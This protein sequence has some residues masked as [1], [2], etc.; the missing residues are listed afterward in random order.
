MKNL[1]TSETKKKKSYGALEEGSLI[2]EALEFMK[3]QRQKRNHVQFGKYDNSIDTLLISMHLLEVPED[4]S[5]SESK[6]TIRMCSAPY[7]H[8]SNLC[9]LA[10]EILLECQKRIHYPWITGGQGIAFGIEVEKDENVAIPHLKAFCVYGAAVQDEWYAISLCYYLSNELF[11]R[12]QYKVAIEALDL[13]DGQILLI[14]SAFSLPRWVDQIGPR[15]IRNRVWIVQN[16]LHL[17]T[18]PL[19]GDRIDSKVCST[20]SDAFLSLQ[21]SIEILRKSTQPASNASTT[22]ASEAIQKALLPRT[23]TFRQMLQTICSRSNKMKCQNEVISHN[24]SMPLMKTTFQSNIHRAA[25]VLPL[26]LAILIKKRPDLT[27]SAVMC[28]CAQAPY[29]FNKIKSVQG[30]NSNLQTSMLENNLILAKHFP[31]QNLVIAI[32]HFTKVGY[33]SLMTGN[34]KI[35]LFNLPHEYR[36]IE[37]TRISRKC[38]IDTSAHFRNAV[39]TGVRLSCGFEWLY[40]Q[41]KNNERRKNHESRVKDPSSYM[42][43]IEK[44][45][46]LYWTRIDQECGGD[47]M[48]IRQCWANGPNGP[49]GAAV[50][51]IGGEKNNRNKTKSSIEHLV[52]CPVFNPEIKENRSLCPLSMI[53]TSI[54]E[55]ICMAIK[56]GKKDNTMKNISSYEMPRAQDVDSDNWMNLSSKELD[57]L[58]NETLSKSGHSNN[59]HDSC[60]S[61]KTESYQTKQTV[62]KAAT[63]SKEIRQPTDTEVLDSILSG[64]KSFV[65]TSSEID[66]VDLGSR[67]DIAFDVSSKKNSFTKRMGYD[68]KNEKEKVFDAYDDYFSDEE[69]YDDDTI[70]S[71]KESSEFLNSKHNYVINDHNGLK[72]R[73]FMVSA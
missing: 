12:Y 47:G 66:G 14:E 56:S 55:Q 31:F 73:D 13:E 62:S 18:P 20:E 51:Q 64:F 25:V 1:E 35:P 16:F 49:N 70:S 23:K 50:S 43:D 6:K 54:H 72:M 33:S 28:F 42:G 68:S 46:L 65:K 44:R 9:V 57:N 45:I 30:S 58:M 36:S 15:G 27:S 11:T 10:N 4:S 2:A 69:Y 52:A 3:E 34:G 17:I 40:S 22:L 26:N 7:T 38:R 39:D 60:M 67:K 5:P 48:W 37:V 53:N 41:S 21:N 63:V 29:Y 8:I 71:E 59:F 24:Y 32:V 19:I 61:P